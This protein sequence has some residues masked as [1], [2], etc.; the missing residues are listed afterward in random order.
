M[1]IEKEIFKR[2][3]IDLNQLIRYG[4]LKERNIYHYS[5][6]FMRHFRADVFVTS[7]GQVTGK[8]YD[9]DMNDEYVNF[10]NDEFTGFA[11]KVR[12]EYI[13]R[14][15]VIPFSSL[16]KQNGMLL[17]IKADKVIIKSDEEEKENDNVIIGIYDKS[18]TKRGEY[19]AL[20]GIELE[21]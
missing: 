9:L 18:L 2:G 20:L 17:G 10:R 12:E 3:S 16:G 15:K 4:F 21:R 7:D 13:S 1:N 19:R 8:V 6:V 5:K 14:L 11:R